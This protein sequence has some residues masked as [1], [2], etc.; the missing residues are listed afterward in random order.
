MKIIKKISII[1]IFLALTSMI[2]NPKSS[3]AGLLS[4]S[5]NGGNTFIE[6]AN[7]NEIF[8]TTNAEQGIGDL[9]YLLLGISIIAAFA[10]GSVIG[11]QF[12]TS[13]VSGKAKIKEKLIPFGLGLIVVFGG[14][15][16]WKL[17]FDIL[18]GAF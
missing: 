8:N 5:L 4:N 7:D 2:L 10:V 12:I 17:V 14:F 18:N 6:N 11:I 15:G 9:Y 1:L 3:E 16:I 13:G